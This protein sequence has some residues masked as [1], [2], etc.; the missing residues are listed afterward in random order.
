MK[1][2]TNKTKSTRYRM[3]A[4][5]AALIVGGLILMDVC[6]AEK[7]AWDVCYEFSN[8]NIVWEYARRMQE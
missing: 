2:N 7:P 3:L 1:Y 8:K 6:T 4:A 5:L